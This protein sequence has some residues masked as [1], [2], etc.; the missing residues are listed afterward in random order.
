MVVSLLWAV[1]APFYAEGLALVGRVFI[2]VLEHAP[3]TRYVVEGGRLLAQ[4]PTWLSKEQ[5]MAP[6]VWPIWVASTNFGVPLL[7]ALIV[8]TPGWS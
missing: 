7:A 2:P 8:A 1:A 3:D 6:L 5:R 4:R